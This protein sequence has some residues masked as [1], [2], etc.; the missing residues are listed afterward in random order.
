VATARSSLERALRAVALRENEVRAWA[1]IDPVGALAAAAEVDGAP[2]G[3]LA[4]T[5]LG[6]KDLF[7]TAGQPT[8]YGSPIFA[9]RVPTTDAVAVTELKRAG[10]VLLGKTVTSELG[11]YHPGPTTN[12]HDSTRTPG[13]S[14]M[15]SAA[16]VAAGMADIALGAQTAA[17]VVRPASFCGVFGF[18]P[19]FG[20]VATDGLRVMAPSLDTVGWFARDAATVGLVTACLVGG[21]P[22][23]AAA[24]ADEGPPVIGLLRTG[25]WEE[26]SPD[27]RRAVEGLAHAARRSGAKVV[28]LDMP[29]AWQS[30]DD[31]HTTVMEYE[32]ARS[33]AAEYQHHRELL[34]V[35]LRTMIERGNAI[36]SRAYHEALATAVEA[37]RV[38]DLAFGKVQVVL[39][40]A[41]VGEAPV[42]LEST[43]DPRFG[44][45]WSLLGLPVLCLPAAVGTAGT[46]IGVQIVGRAGAD[47]QVAAAGAWIEAALRASRDGAA[48]AS[49]TKSIATAS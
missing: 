24:S 48:H 47:K 26:A 38:T 42:G 39:T 18:K 33:L 15:G 43:G 10:A 49:V 1:F 3:P 40:P 21:G 19:T 28:E 22:T 27:S 2:A 11:G 34:S 30:L 44:R 31:V 16:A 14:S 29:H 9:G 4:G 45:L 36:A 7:D 46:P 25:R 12:P 6:V 13:G 5:V 23:T 8:E 37:R 32:A 17:S 20:A 41:V 35:S